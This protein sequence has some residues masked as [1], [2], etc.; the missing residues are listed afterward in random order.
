[1]AVQP[2]D[3][4]LVVV[5]RWE[6]FLFSAVSP[7]IAAVI[8]NPFDVA[9]VR[10]QLQGELSKGGQ[11]V[12]NGSIDCIRKTYRHEGIRGLQ[13]GITP[14]LFREGSKNF[15]RLGLYD[16]IISSIHD[17]TKG[18]AP[19]WKRIIAGGIS[20]AMG[21]AACNPFEILK[22]R[23]QSQAHGTIATGHQFNYTS[24]RN[25]F[26]TVLATE[27]VRGL[28][29]GT[30]T[31][32]ARSTVATGLNLPAYTMMREFIVGGGY[33]R[34]STGVDMLCSVSSAFFTV[35]GIN[36]I[37]VVR[38][39][40][41]NQPVD[42]K[43]Q[44]TLYKNGLDA[45]VK[46]ARAEGV[47]ALYKGWISHFMRLGP[48][49]GLSLSIME[50]FNRVERRR[51]GERDRRT[52]LLEMFQALDSDGDRTISRAELL[53][54]FELVTPRTSSTG[55]GEYRAALQKQVDAVME[56]GDT[57]HNGSLD[58]EEFAAVSDHLAREMHQ[59][60]MRRIFKA[61]DTENTGFIDEAHL[62]NAIKRM[63][64]PIAPGDKYLSQEE[65][66]NKLHRYTERAISAA[67]TNHDGKVDFSEFSEIHKQL[68]HIRADSF[69]RK[70]MRSA[71]VPST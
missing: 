67:D 2:S 21:A 13:K 26:Q 63:R 18:P 31:S 46:V 48:H 15:F 57:D 20:G 64:L 14:A 32:M 51:I 30:T 34:D 71:G 9:K 40:L 38:T 35:L 52:E 55:D 56:R 37:D 61:I 29:K 42:E 1:M 6:G 68:D 27:G 65:Y 50:A 54:M 47:G 59:F 70:W 10:V 12:Y 49:F 33:A 44:G 43:G 22:T 39:R 36:P 5:P 25:G 41:Y 8:T 24:L 11:R 28:Y 53:A 4:R 60:E 17:K 3:R 7:M 23:M 62:F 66:E 16:P 19:A 69:Y 58:F 45:I